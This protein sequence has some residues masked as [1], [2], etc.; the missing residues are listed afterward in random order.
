MISLLIPILEDCRLALSEGDGKYKNLSCKNLHKLRNFV[1][2]LD[3]NLYVNENDEKLWLKLFKEYEDL[4]DLQYCLPIK[5][6]KFMENN[7]WEKLEF[8]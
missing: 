5:I 2:E 8:I 1:D 4:D 7:A 6:R 3:T